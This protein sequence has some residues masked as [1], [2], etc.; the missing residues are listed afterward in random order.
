MDSSRIHHIADNIQHI[1]LYG[2]RKITDRTKNVC[3]VACFVHFQ[4][5]NTQTK[6]KLKKNEHIYGMDTKIFLKVF[7]RVIPVLDHSVVSI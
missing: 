5:C 7:L 1:Y 4:V 2:P 3:F 6:M